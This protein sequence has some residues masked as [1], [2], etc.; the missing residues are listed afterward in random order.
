VSGNASLEAENVA[1]PFYVQ[2]QIRKGEGQMKIRTNVKAGGSKPQ[3]NQTVTRGLKLK[4]N[5]KAGDV[6]NGGGG[7]VGLLGGNHNQP[8]ARGLKV[9]TSVKAGAIGPDI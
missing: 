6:P 5:V 3:H 2:R 4:T 1:A 9:K 8:V 7:T